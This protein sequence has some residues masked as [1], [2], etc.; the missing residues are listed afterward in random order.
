MS[1]PRDSDAYDGDDRPAWPAEEPDGG[2]VLSEGVGGVPD[3]PEDDRA[4]VGDADDDNVDTDEHQT[5]PNR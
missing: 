1:N 2:D 4:T 5:E 3:I